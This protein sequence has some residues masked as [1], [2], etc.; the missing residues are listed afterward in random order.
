MNHVI[1]RPQVLF[2]GNSPP[3]K[4][5]L[6]LNKKNS[7]VREYYMNVCNDKLSPCRHFI[8]EWWRYL[9]YRYMPGTGS[10]D[11]RPILPHSGKVV[12]SE[13]DSASGGV[14]ADLIQSVIAVN[15]ANYA[16]SSKLSLR[17]PLKMWM[18]T[19]INSS[20]RFNSEFRS[21]RARHSNKLVIHC[22]IR[23]AR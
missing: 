18:E 9:R 7:L 20:S 4:H 2:V 23:M 21:S 12:P 6:F 19:K 10:H 14:L 3:R 16:L 22:I 13:E 8:I 5:I 11:H 15:S 17:Q 1:Y